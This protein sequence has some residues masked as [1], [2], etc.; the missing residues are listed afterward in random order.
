MGVGAIALGHLSAAQSSPPSAAAPEPVPLAVSGCIPTTAPSVE[1]VELRAKVSDRGWDYYRLGGYGSVIADP[2]FPYPDVDLVISV[3]GERCRLHWADPDGLN[4]LAMVLP[5]DLAI[6]L[7]TDE[8][9]REIERIGRAEFEANLA[10]MAASE[11]PPT[12]WAEEV[13]ALR[14][15]G[16]AVPEQVVVQ[17]ASPIDRR[18]LSPDW[19]PA[20]P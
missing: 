7:V 17:E 18:L 13:A 20:Q 8:Y 1:R 11:P 6:A 12:W 16:V 5:R 3:R 15:L 4:A 19:E 2:E 10:R 9:Q 14:A